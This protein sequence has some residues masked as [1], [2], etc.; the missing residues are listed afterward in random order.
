MTRKT[1]EYVDEESGVV[2]VRTVEYIEKLIEKE[3][4]NKLTHGDFTFAVHEAPFGLLLLL[5]LP[6]ML[7][8]ILSMHCNL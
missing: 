7:K 2:K 6:L 4:L 1:E 5:Y 3:V 8:M